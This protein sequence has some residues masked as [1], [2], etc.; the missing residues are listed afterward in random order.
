MTLIER[1]EASRPVTSCEDHEREVCDPGTQVAVAAVQ[2]LD[3]RKV[4]RRYR[5]HV[6]A[7]RCKVLNE[8]PV[9]VPVGY[10]LDQVVDLGSNKG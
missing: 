3:F 1:E 5:W 10:S 9:R 6:E 2:L 4:C 7:S 8:T